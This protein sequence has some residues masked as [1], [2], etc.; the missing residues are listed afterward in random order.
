M[1]TADQQAT[2]KRLQ[3]ELKRVTEE[4]DILK[5]PPR[6]LPENPSKVR[7]HP[8]PRVGA[9]HTTYVPRDEYASKRLLCMAHITYIGASA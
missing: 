6:T 7:I 4:R 1:A 8:Q 5:K 3:S 2:I 9:F